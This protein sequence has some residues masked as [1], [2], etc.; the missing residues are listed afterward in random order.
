VTLTLWLLFF[1]ES[2]NV[3]N[4]LKSHT[5]KKRKG[6]DRNRKSRHKKK[7]DNEKEKKK[8]G[9]LR[10]RDRASSAFFK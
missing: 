3:V 5:V 10:K 1:I 2:E 8:K 6:L 4:V 9:W 7:S